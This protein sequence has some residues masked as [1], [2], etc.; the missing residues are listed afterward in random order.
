MH[1]KSGGAMRL[2][3]ACLLLIGSLS[4]QGHCSPDKTISKEKKMAQSVALSPFG[5]DSNGLD[6]V[7]IFIAVYTPKTGMG[8]EQLEISGDGGIALT[9][10]A[11]FKAPDQ[12]IYGKVDPEK[13]AALLALFE[14]EGFMNM[15]RT[16]STKSTIKNTWQMK[17]TLPSGEKPVF[18]EYGSAPPQFYRLMGAVRLLA[19]M[20]APKSLGQQYFFHL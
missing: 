7:R 3:S 20:G 16:Y 10:S 17:L 2:R 13:V 5:L 14:A 19:G 12:N 8:K 9:R 6:K 15:E 4:V 18:A 11:N 1:E